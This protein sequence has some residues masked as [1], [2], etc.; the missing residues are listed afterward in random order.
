[1]LDGVENALHQYLNYH[2]TDQL[3]NCIKQNEAQFQNAQS[4]LC[5]S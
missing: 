5:F 2:G 1:M 4:W 3:N